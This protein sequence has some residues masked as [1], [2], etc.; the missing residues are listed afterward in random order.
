MPFSEIH[1]NRASCGLGYP[2][3]EDE[4]GSDA[5]GESRLFMS[6]QEAAA[7][8]S[9]GWVTS[10]YAGYTCRRSEHSR[11]DKPVDTFPQIADLYELL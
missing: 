8:G 1:D 7:T 5:S 6:L 10:G 9:V 11:S 4:W 3:A 2:C